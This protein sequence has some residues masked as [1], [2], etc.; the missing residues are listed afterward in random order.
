MKTSEHIWQSHETFIAS[1]V[2]DLPVL[3]FCFLR[4]WQPARWHSLM[5]DRPKIT[6]PREISPPSDE[7][8]FYTNEEWHGF[9]PACDLS[10]LLFFLSCVS[11]ATFRASFTAVPTVSWSVTW[12]TIPSCRAS[13]AVTWRPVGVAQRASEVWRRW[14]CGMFCND[15]I[16]RNLLN[17]LL[18]CTNYKW[19]IP[20]LVSDIIR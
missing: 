6:A 4:L 9:I 19:I 17:R 18:G 7:L 13:A 16:R 10:Y 1:V 8:R 12:S 5:S 15:S 3:F 2:E 20:L 11:P 14:W